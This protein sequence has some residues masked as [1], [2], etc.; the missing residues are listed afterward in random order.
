[1]SKMEVCG[2][3]P[4]G[5][6]EKFK[7]Y[8]SNWSY[9][10]MGIPAETVFC[11]A[12]TSQPDDYDGPTRY[13]TQT[14]VQLVDNP[15]SEEDFGPRCKYHGGIVSD[16]K[17]EQD[18]PEEFKEFQNSKPS[19]IKHGLD[20]MD[21]HLRELMTDDEEEVYDFIM[22]WAEA[23][24]FDEEEDPAA[25]DMV[26]QLAI[27]RVRSERS[28][29]YILS[30]SET[31]DKPVFDSQG[32]L[33]ERQDISNA[34]SEGHQRQR[35]LIVKMMKELGITPKER[36]KMDLNDADQSASEAL[37]DVAEQ[38][39]NSDAGEYDPSEFE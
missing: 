17:R 8:Y 21:E 39:L 32:N 20:T 19:Y 25:Y 9:A 1:M 33:V 26:R 30:E 22:S 14:V 10:E 11:L 38:A 27:E 18:V 3:L 24:G 15:E 34:L 36:S 4:E 5:V 7:T 28:A 35:K 31:D 23:Y 6:E 16:E 29:K 13:C 37:A 12:E 2:K